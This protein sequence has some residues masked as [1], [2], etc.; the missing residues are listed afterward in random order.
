MRD[1]TA[2]S[3]TT[4]SVGRAERDVNAE[5]RLVVRLGVAQI[6]HQTD[7]ILNGA[8]SDALRL[9]VRRNREYGDTANILGPKGQF[10]DIHRKVAKLKNILW[11][12]NVAPQ[13]VTESPEEIMMDLIGH[14]LLGI[15]M[16]RESPRNYGGST[17]RFLGTKPDDTELDFDEVPYPRRNVGGG[18]D[19]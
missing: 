18:I 7:M 15:Q 2:K 3:E 8:A 19:G 17:R 16:M 1:E 12:E 14:C 6:S 13:D 11:D 9:F 4:K 5:I 10:A